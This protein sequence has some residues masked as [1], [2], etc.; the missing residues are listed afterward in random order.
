[1]MLKEM[2]SEQET[3]MVLMMLKIK[4]LGEI[5]LQLK[6]MILRPIEIEL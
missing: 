1:M 2:I 3:V 4:M 5:L 6:E